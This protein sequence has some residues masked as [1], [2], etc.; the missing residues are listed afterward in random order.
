MKPTPFGWSGGIE[1]DKYVLVLLT[2]L[3]TSLEKVGCVTL[4]LYATPWISKVCIGG[5]MTKDG[6][7]GEV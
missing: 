1:P 2:S 6:L 3:P 7:A 5:G 4:G